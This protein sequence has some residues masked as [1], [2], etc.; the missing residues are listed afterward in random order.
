[1]NER[2]EKQ[3]EEAVVQTAKNTHG[4]INVNDSNE[5]TL[6]IKDVLKIFN[7]TYAKDK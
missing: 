3:P 6:T 5:M 7:I 1:M 2:T 4:H